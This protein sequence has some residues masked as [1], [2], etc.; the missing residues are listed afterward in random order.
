MIF[1]I[2]QNTPHDH[3]YI[4]KDS[5]FIASVWDSSWKPDSAKHCSVILG[6]P[7]YQTYSTP[8][9]GTEGRTIMAFLHNH[10]ALNIT[11]LFLAL[12]NNPV[13]RANILRILTS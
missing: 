2:T 5:S 10:T 13:T 8:K 1:N 7:I 6:G 4:Y 9:E 3:R 11:H 12:L